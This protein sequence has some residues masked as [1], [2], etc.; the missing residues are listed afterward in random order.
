MCLCLRVVAILSFFNALESAL[1]ESYAVSEINDYRALLNQLLQGLKQNRSLQTSL[2][3]G[4]F[5]IFSTIAR[6]L[7]AKIA[8]KEEARENL[9]KALVSSVV[10]LRFRFHFTC[11]IFFL[12]LIF[13]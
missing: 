13:R 3:Q 12:S 2:K 8:A 7:A 11:A 4:R 5:E 1:L 10:R 9:N 6:Q